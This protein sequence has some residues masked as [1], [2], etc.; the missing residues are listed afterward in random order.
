[1]PILA[2][3]DSTGYKAL[4]FLHI[5]AVIVAF[6]PNFVWPFVAVKLRKAGK[7]TGP[8]IGEMAGG[9]TLKVHGPALVLAGVF[10]FGLV[11]MSDKAIEFSDAWISAGMLVWFLMLGVLFGLMLPAEKRAAA[12]DASAEKVTSMAGGLLHLLLAAELY[13]MVFQ[14]GR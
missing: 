1:V 12:G 4:L 10:G 2:A 14:P 3:I 9:N 5:L 11:G 8:V 13:I 7:P 6:A